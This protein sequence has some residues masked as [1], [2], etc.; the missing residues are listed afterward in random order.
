MIIGSFENLW[1]NHPQPSQIRTVLPTWP[2]GWEPCCAGMSH[3]MNM[4]NLPVTVANPRRNFSYMGRSHYLAVQEMRDYLTRTYGDAENYR[5]EGAVVRS[6]IIS[7][8]TGRR[9]IIVFGHRHIDLWDGSNI[10]G[11]GFILHT[12]WEAPSALREGIFF[13]E[14]GG[15]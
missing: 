4:S 10:H 12:L 14:V 11:H 9:G 7:H 6:A 2:V 3:A 13:W 8:I 15:G 5:Y 1:Q